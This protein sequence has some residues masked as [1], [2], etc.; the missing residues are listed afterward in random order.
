[1]AILGEGAICCAKDFMYYSSSLEIDDVKVCVLLLLLLL[2]IYDK[3]CVS[4][5]AI[6]DLIKKGT[7]LE[8]RE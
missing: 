4:E 6:A 5:Y 7:I 2:F 1:M 8:G 3:L